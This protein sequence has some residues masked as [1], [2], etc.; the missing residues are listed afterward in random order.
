MQPWQVETQCPQCGAP[1]TLKEA[2]HVL[3][4]PYCKTRLYLTSRGPFRYAISPKPPLDETVFLPFWRIKGLG[5]TAYLPPKTVGKPIDKTFLAVPAPLKMVSLGMRPQATHLTFAH[6][7]KGPF[8][9]P[10]ANFKDL[11][12][13]VTSD[14]VM[15]RMAAGFGLMHGIGT[16]V[17]AV[18]A[19]ILMARINAGLTA[20]MLL[21]LPV[22]S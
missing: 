3:N 2:Q 11:M 14:V 1:I 6:T 13:R 20:A 15:V 18:L 17:V 7:E 4:C 22:L 12:A 8:L 5:F 16:A 21:G 10:R 19:L 9:F